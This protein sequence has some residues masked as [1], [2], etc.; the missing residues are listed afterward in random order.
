MALGINH[1][2]DL[3]GNGADTLEI[4]LIFWVTYIMER[5]TTLMIGRNSSL[6]DEYIDAWYPSDNFI[7]AD[8]RQILPCGAITNWAYIRAMAMLAG[9]ADE[10]LMGIY[11]SKV[12]L[13]DVQSFLPTNK[14]LECEARL[15]DIVNSLPAHLNCLDAEAP[16]GEAW[17]EIQ[18]LQFGVTLETMRMLTHRPALVFASFFPSVAEA[19]RNTSLQL[20]R[21]IELCVGSA[22]AIIRFTHHS[23]SSRVPDA[24]SD[25]SPAIYLTSACLTLLFHV[26]D[27]DTT[28][29]SA[30]D[31]FLA[32]DQAIQCLEDMKHA[33]PATGK[34]LSLD[35]MAMAQKVIFSPTGQAFMSEDRSLTAEYPWLE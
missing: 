7:P 29:E 11:N 18:R 9:L 14:I 25:G 5:M 20:G 27:P 1:S 6:R 28:L 12:A 13:L 4:S 30:K 24:R 22:K 34:R 35:I 26:L 19:Q 17:Q 15:Q 31:T 2:F 10:I 16:V 32:L 21:S 33:G 23:L 3:E 8:P